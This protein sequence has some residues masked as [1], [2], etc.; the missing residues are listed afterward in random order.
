MGIKRVPEMFR[1]VPKKLA[2]DL[3]VKAHSMLQEHRS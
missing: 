2:G 3:A 1:L